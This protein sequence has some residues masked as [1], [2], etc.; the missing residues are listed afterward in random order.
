MLFVSVNQKDLVE[1][2][3]SD[4]PAFASC[5]SGTIALGLNSSCFQGSS[6]FSCLMDKLKANRICGITVPAHL[7]D[8]AWRS[9]SS[10]SLLIEI[11]VSLTRLGYSFN[12]EVAKFDI[13]LGFISTTIGRWNG[14]RNFSKRGIRRTSGEAV[15]GSV[16]SETLEVLGNSMP[17]YAQ[18]LK[19]ETVSPESKKVL[20]IGAGT[21]TMTLLF[22]ESAFVVAFEPSESARETLSVNSRECENVLTVSSIEEAR[23]AGPYDEVVLINVLEHVEHDTALLRQAR[24]LLVVGGRLTVLSPAHN[25]LYSDF[26]ASIGHVRRYTRSNIE[27]TLQISGFKEIESTYFNSIG[28]ILWFLVNRLA[29]KSEASSSQTNLYDKFVVPISDFVNRS[30]IRPF[31]QS[32]IA[33]GRRK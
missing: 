26:D 27:R 24:D 4:L 15:A 1:V 20:E 12:S 17:R 8:Q 7:L 6:S 29:R 25:M 21:G 5:Q 10:E 16:L 32:V 18:W 3:V 30:R 28:A 11:F 13:D 9:K 2:S 23:N 33:H 19:R 14:W 22:A 31:G